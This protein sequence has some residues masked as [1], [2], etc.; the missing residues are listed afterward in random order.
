[1]KKL[2]LLFAASAMLVSCSLYEIDTQ[3]PSIPSGIRTISLDN[4]VQLD[5]NPNYERDFAGYHVWVSDAFDG[6]YTLIGTTKQPQ[7]VDDGAINGVTYYYGVTSYDFNGNESEMSRDVAYDTPR[8]E[9][10]NV[11]LYD[12]VGF[13]DA[14]GYDFST[15]SIGRYDDQYSDMFFENANGVYY[16]NVWSDT[17]IQDMGYTQTL[18]DISAAPGGGWSPSGSVEAIIG[19][20]YVIWTWDDDYAKVRVKSIS[21]TR[22]IF[23]WAYQTAPAN[24]ELSRAPQPAGRRNPTARPELIRP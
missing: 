17:D 6:T 5:W 4:A 14:S 11:G 13:P 10:Y 20:T 15:Y 18:D 8:P 24:P 7:F 1:M 23:D 9:G 12:F 19:H 16:L 3:P 2:T 22:I 21:A